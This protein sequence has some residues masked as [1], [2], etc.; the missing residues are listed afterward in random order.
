MGIILSIIIVIIMDIIILD[1]AIDNDGHKHWANNMDNNGHKNWDN[2]KLMNIIF[3][4]IT[5]I[6]MGISIGT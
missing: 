4:I 5:L 2:N 6:K 1:N 3:R